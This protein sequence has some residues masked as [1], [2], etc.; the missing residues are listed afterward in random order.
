MYN[1][2]L[3]KTNPISEFTKEVPSFSLNRGTIKAIE[4]LN[5]SIYHKLFLQSLPPNEDILFPYKIYFQFMNS[6]ILKS[7]PNER[8]FWSNC[9]KFF[10]QQTQGKPGNYFLNYQEI[11]SIILSETLIFLRKT[12]MSFT[13][14][15]KIKK[16]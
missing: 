1:S 12:S 10:L 9:C 5:E 11:I 4:L 13:K 15:V 16:N 2:I 6:S 14:C 3:N 7:L 8:E